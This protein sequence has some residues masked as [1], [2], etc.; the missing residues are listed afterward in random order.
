MVMRLGYV[1]QDQ[2]ELQYAAKELARDVSKPTERS[3]LALVDC[4]WAP[5]VEQGHSLD[6]THRQ[7]CEATATQ[8]GLDARGDADK[9]VVPC[10]STDST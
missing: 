3:E 6:R 10:C 2:S 8:I 1:A 4:C 7:S 5:D 9:L